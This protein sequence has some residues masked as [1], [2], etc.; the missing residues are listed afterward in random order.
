LSTKKSIHFIVNPISGKGRN[1]LDANTIF[2]VLDHKHFE[3]VI[4]TTKHANNAASLTKESILEGANAII[5]CGGDGT[6]NE[7][8]SQLVGSS[9]KLGIIRLGSGNGLASHLGIS[10]SI[11]E[12]LEVIKQNY[13][14]KIDVGVVN[15]YFFFS[16]MSLG[17]GARIINHYTG[18]KK[19]Q[20]ISYFRASLK[21]LFQKSPSQLIDLEIDGFKKTID[22]LVLFVSNSNE[23]GY[24]LSFTPQ[25]SLQDGKLDVVCTEQLTF[26]EKLAFVKQ[27]IIHKNKRY[28]K[29]KYFLTNQIKVTNRKGNEFLTQ[30]DGES[31]LIQSKELKISIKQIALNV[32][33]PKN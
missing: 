28:K 1:K 14:K 3:V 5:A 10:N 32:L 2:S 20:I 29:A 13:S 8:A 27:L 23:M 26:F 25:A 30:V 12:A 11:A 21:A 31:I 9:V 6:V 24:N 22:P 16:N 4:K 15:D 33:V 7:V 19:R 18:F 17:I